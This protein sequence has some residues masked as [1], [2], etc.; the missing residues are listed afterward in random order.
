[1]VNGAAQKAAP[2]TKGH[3]GKRPSTRGAVK[4]G[5][6]ARE[7]GART[8]ASHSPR[9]D[10]EHGDGSG[11]V[12]LLCRGRS[13]R[14]LLWKT[15]AFLYFRNIFW[16][17]QSSRRILKQRSVARRLGGGVLGDAWRAATA[18]SAAEGKYRLRH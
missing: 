15:S 2:L 17:L 16:T 8:N 4:T 10:G 3:E 7:A 5:E 11:T 12:A 9:L 6:A 1:L 14:A 18:N 13:P